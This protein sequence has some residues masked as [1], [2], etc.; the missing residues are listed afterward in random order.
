MIATHLE[1]C[2]DVGAIPE[3]VL[4]CFREKVVNCFAQAF[5]NMSIKLSASTKLGAAGWASD[6]GVVGRII[7]HDDAGVAA[8][9]AIKRDGDGNL[10]V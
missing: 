7:G 2:L 4:Q 1:I 8:Y 6:D 5:P 3:S 9:L 10:I